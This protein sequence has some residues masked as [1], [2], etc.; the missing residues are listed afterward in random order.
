[1]PTLLATVLLS[2]SLLAASPRTQVAARVVSVY[3]GDTIRVEAS[4]WPG[5]TWQGSVRVRGI[6]TPE[7]RGKCPEEKEMALAARDFV[8]E[9]VGREIILVDF[10][11][12]KYAGR[13]VASVRL[14]NGTDLTE[15]LV[16]TGHG[17]PYDGGAREPWC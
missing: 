11:R 6:D 9:Q 15:V 7:L 3:D 1:M 12:G 10:E 16:K 5:L 8:R 2:A 14:T 17:R 13:V 4:I